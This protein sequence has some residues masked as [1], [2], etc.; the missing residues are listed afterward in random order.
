MT[1]TMKGVII[2]GVGAPYKVV[3][4]LEVPEPGEGQVLVKSIATAINP[5]ET[6]MSS[7]GL[8]IKSFPIVL[9]CDSSGIVTKVGPNTSLKPGQR[10]CG[11]TRLGSPGYSTFQ[12]YF[13]FDERFAIL[14]PSSLSYNDAATIGVGAET[15]CIGLLQGIKLAALDEEGNVV[16]DKGNN[17]EGGKGW[18]IVLGGAGSVGQ[19]SV[20]IAKVLGYKVVATCSKR[21]ADLVKSLGADEVVDYSLSEDEQ[22]DKIK[23]ITGGD[24]FGVWDT[25]AKYEALGC[26]LLADASISKKPKCYATTDGWAQTKENPDYSIHRANLGYIGRPDEESGQP[27]LDSALVSYAKFITKLLTEGNLKPNQTDIVTGGFDAVAKAVEKQSKGAGGK[28]VVVELQ[29]VE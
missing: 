1:E 25:V 14:P 7:T 18:V 6:G 23:E 9:G 19:Y 22:Y 21:S 27:G 29:S 15:A 8:L 3:E 26:K 16:E 13:L 4:D 20:Q 17:K 28:K 24:F 5:V 10:I 2:E 12:Q 11:C